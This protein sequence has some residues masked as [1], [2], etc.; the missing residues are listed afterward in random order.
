MLRKERKICLAAV[1]LIL[2][3]S[4][5]IGACQ[6][7]EAFDPDISWY[8]DKPTATKFEIN[9]MEQLYGLNELCTYSKYGANNFE[10]K[11]IVLTYDI[12]FG[13]SGFYERTGGRNVIMPTFKGTFDGNGHV[14]KNSGVNFITTNAGTVSN[15]IW[16]GSLVNTNSAT[17]VIKGCVSQNGSLTYTNSGTIDSCIVTGTSGRI[18]MYVYGPTHSSTATHNG[19]VKDCLMN[20]SVAGDD[21]NKFSGNPSIINYVSVRSSGS[22]GSGYFPVNPHNGTLSGTVTN[23]YGLTGMTLYP[24]TN[25]SMTNVALKA[26][27]WFQSSSAVTTLGS[28]WTLSY[29]AAYQNKIGLTSKIAIPKQIYT[30]LANSYSIVPI[31][32]VTSFM[33]SDTEKRIPV[34]SE[35]TLVPSYT[36]SNGKVGTT[37][38][39]SSKPSVA[40]VNNGKVKGLSVGFT[41]VSLH[42]SNSDMTQS[43]L[44]YV[45]EP[46]KISVH[47]TFETEHGNCPSV[48]TAFYR[49]QNYTDTVSYPGIAAVAGSPF[50]SFIAEVPKATNN[51]NFGIR[52]LNSIIGGSTRTAVSGTST[53]I[54]LQLIEG[55]LNSDN[56][57]DASDYTI[58]V[59]RLNYGGGTYGIGL[60]G[61][62]NC[63]G[64]VNEADKFF[65]NAPIVYSGESRYLARGFNMTT[66]AAPTSTF[67]AFSTFLELSGDELLVELDTPNI[68]TLQVALSGVS[69]ITDVVVPEGWE[70]LGQSEINGS[71]VFAL[72]NSEIDGLSLS[73]GVLATL[74]NTD[75]PL[76]DETYSSMAL[77]T[78]A[79]VRQLDMGFNSV[80]KT[81]ATS[82]VASDS[83]SSGCNAGIGMWAVIFCSG[84]LSY[85]GKGR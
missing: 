51:W 70:L 84:L 72:G 49:D 80:T 50:H 62:L 59:Q 60:T 41:Y 32:K 71:T 64:Y 73:S 37:T 17:G 66:T 40:T 24:W 63:D 6:S 30:M 68:T 53:D 74:N 26:L 34:G 55:D 85:V 1:A 16:G 48:L 13:N 52:S 23:S 2:T 3:I 18:A 12:D 44:V 76:F 28:Q 29:T 78:E 79:G 4:M 46:E 57:I 38:W 8:T 39:T 67:A 25:L 36:P 20:V 54:H 47:G 61:D 82:D 83:G 5:F 31:S 56:I 19:N 43:V 69:S 45:T 75:T 42:E 27:S 15:L 14:I 77:A 22:A 10:G 33:F 7:A 58:L 21:F 11:T 9:T 81:T 35:I 65:F